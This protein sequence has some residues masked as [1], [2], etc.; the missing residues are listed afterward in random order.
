[1][2]NDNPPVRVVDRVFQVVADSE[3][4]L[5]SQDLRYEDADSPPSQIQYT[6]RDIPNGA[7]FHADNMA[8]QVYRFT[9]ADLDSGKI[10]FRHSGAPSARA[11][12][13]VTD[14]QYYAS[15]VLEIRAS[16]PFVRVRP[17][18]LPLNSSLS[19]GSR[20]TGRH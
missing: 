8:V 1:M 18:Q 19:G 17:E 2:R 12:L 16:K 4:P 13:W 15:G 14:G 5:T 11:V 6:R 7:L 9:Q 10:I 3:R 20:S